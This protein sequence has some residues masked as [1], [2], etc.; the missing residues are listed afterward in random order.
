ML[1][2]ILCILFL[3][4]AVFFIFPPSCLALTIDIWHGSEQ[5]VGHLGPAQPD[6]NVMGH[7]SPYHDIASLSYSVNGD[8]EVALSYEAYR[9]LA[10]DGDF[11]ADIAIESLQDGSNT[12]TITAIDKNDNVKTKSMTITKLSGNQ[13]F[14]MKIDWSKVDN[15]Q[16][17]GQYVD[18]KWALTNEGLLNERTGYDRIFLIGN[19][20]WEDYDITAKVIIHSVDQSTSSKS[21]PNGLGILMRFAGHAVGG[22]K[23][24]PDDQPK[25]GYLPF[26]CIGWLRW[27]DGWSADPEICHY[28]GAGNSQSCYGSFD[29]QLDTWLKMRLRAETLPDEGSKGVTKY[30]FKIWKDAESEPSNWNWEKTQKSEYALRS[31]GPALLSHHVDATFGDVTIT[32]L[33]GSPVRAHSIN[34]G[35]TKR[36]SS[37]S[38]IHK[39]FSP[40]H[41]IFLKGPGKR[42][43]DIHGRLFPIHTQR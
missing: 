3:I 8:S 24:W 11:N 32:D 39:Q 25:W 5:K 29:L 15:P 41:G 23:D 42:T 27:K 17:V 6:F 10:E 26:G 4:S 1:Y 40:E 7:V 35:T 21:G 37:R 14:P 34:M 38:V 36:S 22:F 43:F 12:V 28:H 30:S 13:T 20:N 19:T 18:G 33:N 9:R 2:R 16:N 31:G